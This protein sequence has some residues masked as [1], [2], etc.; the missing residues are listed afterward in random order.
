MLDPSVVSF[1]LGSLPPP[2]VR[3]LEVGAGEG[4]LAA[5]LV[6][7][8]YDV[9][10]ID[11]AVAV[12][13]V[14]AV[15]LHELAEPAA[16]FDAALAIVSLHHVNPLEESCRRLGELVRPGGTLVLDEIDVDR[17]DERAGQWWLDRRPQDLH[18]GGVHDGER[19]REPEEIVADLHHHCHGLVFLDAAL[20]Q[21][22]ELGPPVRGPYLYRWAREPELRAEE[23]RLIDAGELPAT[24]VRIVGTRR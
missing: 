13:G 22:F 15:A 10:A 3:V 11:P 8:G 20:R 19:E 4:E 23:E 14:R 1:A 9:V 24:G 21:C 16:S 17:C 6:A 18:H 2:P 12:P 7:A 5:A